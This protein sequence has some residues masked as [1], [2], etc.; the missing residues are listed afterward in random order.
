MITIKVTELTTSTADACA[1]YLVGGFDI[2]HVHLPAMEIF[3]P[4]QKEALYEICAGAEA[5]IY[6]DRKAVEDLIIQQLTKPAEIMHGNR[7]YIFD[8]TSFPSQKALDYLVWEVL[9]QVNE[10]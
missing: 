2:D 7:H 8:I 6:E 10:D 1:L 9:A 5:G 3:R 4:G